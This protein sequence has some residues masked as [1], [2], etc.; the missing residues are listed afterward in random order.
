MGRR[1]TAATQRRFVR[2]LCHTPQVGDTIPATVRPDPLLSMDE[3]TGDATRCPAAPAA[4]VR[5]DPEP[6]SAA[7]R[8]LSLPTFR[9]DRI[10]HVHRQG[11][12]PPRRSAWPP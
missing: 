4:T 12:P 7:S 11:A 2:L 9:P 8:F 3:P 6:D 10:T 1:H 5:T